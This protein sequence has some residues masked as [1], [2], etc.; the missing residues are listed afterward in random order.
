MAFKVEMNSNAAVSTSRH[1]ELGKAFHLDVA[2]R[3]AESYLPQGCL[4]KHDWIDEESISIREFG[5][6]KLCGALVIK[7]VT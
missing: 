1:K 6:G 4:W 2:K 5:N 3:L 7:E